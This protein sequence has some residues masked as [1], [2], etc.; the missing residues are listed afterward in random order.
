MTTYASGTAHILDTRLP[1]TDAR[2]HHICAGSTLT[3]VLFGGMMLSV[4]FAE[5]I[6]IGTVI[7]GGRCTI[8]DR[9][10]AAALYSYGRG[11]RDR[12]RDRRRPL[13]PTEQP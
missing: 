10:A 5:A 4:T 7:G 9:P 6:V 11:D 2:P 1:H 12:H 13:H 3:V 8:Y